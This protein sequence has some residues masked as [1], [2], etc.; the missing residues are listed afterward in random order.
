MEKLFNNKILL[1]NELANEIRKKYNIEDYYAKKE[2]LEYYEKN[3][4]GDI[5]YNFY[6]NQERKS[7]KIDKD[8][9]LKEIY[10]KILIPEFE[11]HIEFKKILQYFNSLEEKFPTKLII[12]G[13]EFNYFT[14]SINNLGILTDIYYKEKIKSKHHFT[15]D[16]NFSN[17][18]NR[19]GLRYSLDTKQ[20]ILYEQ[21]KGIK[22]KIREIYFYYLLDDLNK[23]YKSLLSFDIK[24]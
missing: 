2:E 4:Q 8:G 22:N 16:K 20:I 10:E 3:F 5:V 13:I 12:D 15:K 9:N 23:P 21:L 7:I 17:I 6:H 19:C 14:Y 11:A 18:Y 1:A 24:K